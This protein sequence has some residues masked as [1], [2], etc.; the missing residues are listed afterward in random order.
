MSVTCVNDPPIAGDDSFTGVNATLANTRLVV[1]TTSTGSHLVV[2]GSVLT[3]DTDVDTPSGLTAGPATISSANCAGCNNVTMEADGN[4]I[5]DPPA[6]FTGNDTFTYTV[7][8]ND[9]DTP[10]NQTD[11]ATV[12]IEVVGPVVWYVDIDAAAPPAGQGGR[13]HSPFNSLTPLTTGGTADALDG[14][15][16]II[17][18]DN[19]DGTVTGYSGGIVLETNQRL[20][21]NRSG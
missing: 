16:N 10:A 4:F 11:T 15:G 2:T 5:Y 13:S 20:R 17:F 3:N 7:N 14:D 1:G 9:P 19:D 8:D 12:T 21:V 18:L 6:G